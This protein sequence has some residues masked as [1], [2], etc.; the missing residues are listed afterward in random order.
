MILPRS[1]SCSE[2]LIVNLASL[3][4]SV[5]TLEI[6]NM[7]TAD[8]IRAIFEP[9]AKGD[10]ASFWPHVEPDVDWTVKGELA[11]PRLFVPI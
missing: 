8:H 11:H 3:F 10:M 6:F 4:T 9:I 5:N 2:Q 7:V 1:T